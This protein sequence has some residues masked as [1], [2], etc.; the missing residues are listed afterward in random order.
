MHQPTDGFFY[1][2]KATISVPST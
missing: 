1:H 2:N